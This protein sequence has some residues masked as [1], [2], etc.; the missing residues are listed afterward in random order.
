MIA[1][2][3]TAD[4]AARD[5]IRNSLAESLL[6][7]AAAGTGK[8]TELVRRIVNI[9]RQG[10]TTIDRIV[11]VTFTQKA[12]GE[13]KLRLRQ[14]LDRAR[15]ESGI[16]E[17]QSSLEHALAHLEEA[18]IGTIHAFCAQILR[19]RPVEAR[20]DPDFEEMDEPAAKRIYAGVFRRWLEEKLNC[21][22]PGLRR[23]LARLAVREERELEYTPF[24]SLEQ[25]GWRLMEWRDFP[26]GWQRPP[27]DRETVIDGLIENVRALGALGKYNKKLAEPVRDMQH[28]IERQ[29]RDYDMLEGLLFRLWREWKK[30]DKKV[31]DARLLAALD[32]LRPVMNADLAAQVRAEMWELVGLY[33]QAKQRAGKLDFVDLLLLVR[34]LVRD[35]EQVRGY[36]QDK[37]THLLIDEFQDTDPLQ[38]EILL[39]LAADDARQT[40]WLEVRPAPG[41]L[42]LVGDPKQ[43]I[44]KFRRADV[45]LYQTLLERLEARGVGVVHLTRSFRSVPTIQKCVNAAFQ[46]E[47]KGDRQAAQPDYVPL[48]EHR[49]DPPGQ[50]AVVALPAPRPFGFRGITKAAID[51]CFPGAVVGFVQWLLEES[52]W[53]VEDPEQPG[54][55][56]PVRARD[57]CILFRRFMNWGQDLTRPYA[58]ALEDRGIPHLLVG[59]KTFHWREE[60]DTVRAALTA[61]EWPEDE[62]A[63]FAT[64][65]GAL[66]AVPDHVLLSYRLEAG[67]LDPFRPAPDGFSKDCQAVV[68]ALGLLREL[69]LG[70]NRRPIA[71]SVFLLLEAARAWAAFAVRPAGHQ[72][73]SNVRRVIDLARQFETGGGISF[74][75]FVEELN[76]Q[77]DK[78]ESAEAPVLEEGADGVRIMTVHAAKGLEFPVVILA[79]MTANIS[80]ANPEKHVDSQRGLCAMRLLGCAPLE[81]VSQE[82]LE[83]KREQAEGVRVAYVAATR[84]RDLLVAPVIGGAEP[85]G[86]WTS[87]LN[88]AVYPSHQHRRASRPAPGCPRF[89]EVSLL[90]APHPD[91]EKDSIRPGLHEARGGGHRVVWWDPALLPEVEEERFGERQKEVFADDAA[92]EAAGL[93]EHARWH[94]QR[95]ALL[96]DGARP[97]VTLRTASEAEEPPPGWAG[98]VLVEYAERNPARPSG[99]RFGTLVH[100]ALRDVPLDAGQDQIDA[101]AQLQARLLAAPK[102]ETEAAAFAVRMALR[103]PLLERARTARRRHREYPLTL[104]LREGELLEGVIDLAFE[105][106]GQW[107]IVDFKSDADMEP[108]LPRYRSQIAWYALALGRITGMPV[109]CYLLAV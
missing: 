100:H 11:A 21:E 45:H 8:T 2:A 92:A 18:A 24:E 34:N 77:A 40:N 58:R 91:E 68:D 3:R 103:H 23:A 89:G 25:A 49:E 47:M 69:H 54:V 105:E 97:T 56:A 31:P 37:Y 5:R 61:I 26:A 66:F 53:R 35:N 99:K 64:L 28:W 70:R 107:V 75:G 19:E 46:A 63:V 30:E 22:S 106:H 41:K 44:Y 32:T 82:S 74:R 88:K 73:L 104:A 1:G 62:L 42:F 4:D 20:V 81:L 83:K 33:G 86:W 60:I 72:V 16:P 79:D 96:R 98:E 13:L 67:S 108:V 90:G 76:S 95:E 59:S 51:S 55:R 27:L 29:P 94:E 38:A 10:L 39:L 80:L 36:L 71:E 85:S 43:S 6:V 101:L 7:E 78:A 57:I 65:K 48:E 17:E 14:E 109:Q 52:G 87:P 9:L 84:A 15:Q 50:P 12:A 93:A 102:E